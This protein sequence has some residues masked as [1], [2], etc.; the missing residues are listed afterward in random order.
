MFLSS[1][2]ILF[3][4]SKVTENYTFVYTCSTYMKG[5]IPIT[6]LSSYIYSCLH[7]HPFNLVS[8]HLLVSNMSLTYS[9]ISY[10]K[11]YFGVQS[12]FVCFYLLT[13][14]LL[15][16]SFFLSFSGY[17][18][19]LFSWF[20]RLYCCIGFLFVFWEKNLKFRRAGHR[21]YGNT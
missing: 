4:F 19:I 1:T 14:W 3:Y 12:I 5:I 8:Y 10:I 7:M 17:S 6:Y 15:F 2:C 20:W 11:R 9:W 16:F 13:D 21:G 18:F